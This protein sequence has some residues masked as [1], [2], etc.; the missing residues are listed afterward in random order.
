MTEGTTNAPAAGRDGTGRISGA[1]RS[2]EPA[3]VRVLMVVGPAAGGIGAHVQSLA[4]GLVAPARPGTPGSPAEPAI[5]LVVATAAGTADRFDLGPRAEVLWPTGSLRTRVRRLH[6]L[7]A[8]AAGADVVHAQGHQAGLLALAAVAASWPLRWVRPALSAQ[9]AQPA[10]PVQPGRGR[11]RG[12]RA[13]VVISWHN[14]VLGRGPARRVRAGLEV[15]Q[16]RGADVVTGASQDLVDRAATLG[17]RSADLAPVAAPVAAAGTPTRGPARAAFAAEL[18]LDPDR[19]W[20]LTVSRLAPQKNLHVLVEAAR[21]VGTDLATGPDPAVRPDAVRPDAMGPEVA[22][23]EAP[24]PARGAVAPEWVV[25]GDGRADL[26]ADL[27]ESARAGGV[28]LHLVGARRDVAAWMAA[29]DLFVLPSA[30]E[31]RALVVQ[32]ALAAGLPVVTTAVG[33]LPEL[34]GDAGV[35]VPVDD[36][37]AL[38]AAVGA[39]LRD[40]DRRVRLAAD[41]R[42]RAGELPDEGAVVAAWADRYRT[43]ARRG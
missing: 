39:L 12:R 1:G 24:G 21:R 41:G 15:M 29:A 32:E 33:G 16:A 3:A 17:A 5:D 31:A 43:L 7:T 40:P 35:L 9:P 36:P 22:G 38:A 10:Q 37:E 19:P 30:W 34:V 20:V 2:A 11:R 13:A 8:L 25:V 23:P 4:R 42:R 27:R 18:G 28:R 6:R 26:L 14:A